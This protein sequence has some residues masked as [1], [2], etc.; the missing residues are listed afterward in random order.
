MLRCRTAAGSSIRR[1]RCAALPQPRRRA[2]GALGARDRRHLHGEPPALD[3]RARGA[4][5]RSPSSSWSSSA[6]CA[7]RRTSSA[8]RPTTVHD[9]HAGAGD[10]PE[11]DRRD[12]AAD[13]RAGR[14]RRLAALA[15]APHHA[16]RAAEAHRHA[17][18]LSRPP[19][20]VA[21]R[22]GSSAARSSPAS[23]SRRSAGGS[24][25]PTWTSPS[26][27]ALRAIA[28]A[29]LTPDD[30]DGIASY[31][32][33]DGR[34]APPGFAGPGI[35]DVQ[36]ALGLSRAAGTWRG[37]R[38]RRRSRPS[39]RRRSRSAAGL[40]RH[41]LVY[42]T[43]S[44]ATAAADTGRLGIGAGS[45]EIARLR[46]VPDPVRRHVGGQLDRAATRV[47]HMHEFGTTREHLGAIALDGARARGAQSRRRSTASR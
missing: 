40:A 41:V 18:V 2:R 8:A 46:R 7:S 39:S 45:R 26:E 37:R 5:R 30:I 44:E 17:E 36:D 33:A 24:S 1:G 20:R 32:G 27:A 21:P 15:D 3:A 12:V 38:A 43:V 16:R 31:P 35:D 23:G 11:D 29:G 4:V 19:R 6:A 14:R 28:D 34:G 10:V 47:R 13:L 42:R 9:R 25:A 22:S